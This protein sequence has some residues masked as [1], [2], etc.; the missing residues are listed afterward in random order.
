MPEKVVNLLEQGRELLSQNRPKDALKLIREGLEQYPDQHEAFYLM[1]NACELLDMQDQALAFLLKAHTLAPHNNQ[2]IEQIALHYFKTSDYHEAYKHFKIIGIQKLDCLESLNAC[3]ESAAEVGDISSAIEAFERSY[4]FNPDQDGIKKKLRELTG[5]TMQKQTDN[6][7]TLTFFTTNDFFLKDIKAHYEGKLKVRQFS[8]STISEIAGM[9]K[10]SELCWFEWCDNL[11]VHASKLPKYG[12]TICRL[13]RYEAFT[14]MPSKVNWKNVDH[15]ICVSNHMADFVKEKFEVPIPITAIPNGI[16]LS[17]FAPPEN[18][19]YGKNVAYVGFIKKEKGPE[20]LAQCFAK[21]HSYDTEYRFHIAGVHQDPV[22][23]KY[24]NHLCTALSIPIQYHG[25]IDDIASWMADKDYI[26]SSSMIEGCPYSVIE[27]I[28]SGLI[29]LVHNWPGSDDFYP[30][31]MMFKT[32]DECLELLK[33]YEKSNKQS[34]TSVNRK[35]MTEKFS[36]KK[37]LRAVDEI[38]NLYL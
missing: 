29:P 32:V 27:G 31:E 15:L 20:L 25:W 2:Y 5:N 35:I 26:I 3:G 28:S 37:H 7:K 36:L 24:F 14:D 1:A 34:V 18:N 6:R 8:G 19:I 30:K 22:I 9:M 17:K 23:E 16:D 21:I 11:I 12:K 10:E 38:V 13:H 33:Q 4:S